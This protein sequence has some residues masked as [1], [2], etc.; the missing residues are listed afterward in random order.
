MGSAV[1]RAASHTKHLYSN[2]TKER[3]ALQ[4]LSTSSDSIIILVQNL[5]GE[6]IHCLERQ[7]CA[8]AESEVVVDPAVAAAGHQ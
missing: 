2:F 6:N 3:N 7:V 4:N 1:I 5:K 8:A